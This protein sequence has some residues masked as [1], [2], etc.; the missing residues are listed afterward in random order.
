MSR[1]TR[2]QIKDIVQSPR[3]DGGHS[4]V[5]EQTNTLG[6][7][8][9]DGR[10]EVEDLGE[11]RSI[12]NRES[13]GNPRVQASQNISSRSRIKEKIGSPENNITLSM[14]RYFRSLLPGGRCPARKCAGRWCAV[15]VASC[16]VR[17]RRNIYTTR[18]TSGISIA[19][20]LGSLSISV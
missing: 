18:T 6:D 15:V 19:V 16:D 3:R 9:S 20:E 7:G 10:R 12:Q 1:A 17:T 11:N 14:D 5:A 2:E 4:L 8:I 13:M